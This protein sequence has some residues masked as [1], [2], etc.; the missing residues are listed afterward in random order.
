AR[1]FTIGQLPGAVSRTT[2]R[3]RKESDFF[4]ARFELSVPTRSVAEAFKGEAECVQS[5]LARNTVRPMRLARIAQRPPPD[6]R[7]A[8][9]PSDAVVGVASRAGDLISLPSQS[10]EEVLDVLHH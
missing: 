5:F 1:P 7:H 3:V 8:G 4:E 10:W 6:A 9:G 2:L